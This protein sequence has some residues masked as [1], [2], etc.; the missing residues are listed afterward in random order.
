VVLHEIPQEIGDFGVLLYAGIKP[1]R[2]LLYNLASAL[3]SV[4]G[5]ALVL[6]LDGSVGWLTG[7][8]VPFAAGNFL[9]IA[10]SDLVPELK[11]QKE[12]GKS[13]VQLGF[14]VLGVL[15]MYLLKVMG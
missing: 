8:L 15:L 14:M 6:M 13:L 5:A 2:A 9:Y 3:T 4:I 1:R 7:F 10:G 12:V 11:D